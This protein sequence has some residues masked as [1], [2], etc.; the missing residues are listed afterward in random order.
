[1][2]AKLEDRHGTPQD[3]A[4]DQ[5]VLVLS[6][7][8][9]IRIEDPR[10]KGHIRFDATQDGYNVYIHLLEPVECTIRVARSKSLDKFKAAM[11]GPRSNKIDIVKE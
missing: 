2:I 5:S 1:M 11:F 7:P 10:G 9:T 6:T 8:H 3:R 4:D